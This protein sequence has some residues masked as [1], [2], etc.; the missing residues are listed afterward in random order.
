MKFAA[1]TRTG[2]NPLPPL[3]GSIALPQS[4]ADPQQPFA[5]ENP[6]KAERVFAACRRHRPVRPASPSLEL[7]ARKGHLFPGQTV[8]PLGRRCCQAAAHCGCC[9]RRQ[10][11]DGRRPDL[12]KKK[13][14]L[15]KKKEVQRS[16]VNG[17]RNPGGFLIHLVNSG[18]AGTFNVVW[19]WFDPNGSAQNAVK[20]KK[21]NLAHF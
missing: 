15:R 6:H 3:F 17:F 14:N 4:P 11:A 2:R 5:G 10:Q 13:K 9:I 21:K 8:T 19:I 20:K 18:R 1:K 12:K 16:R 7:V